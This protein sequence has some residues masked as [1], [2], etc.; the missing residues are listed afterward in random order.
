MKTTIIAIA[1][2]FVAALAPAFAQDGGGFAGPGP[3]VITVK[4]AKEMRDDSKVTL[5]GYI[6][7]HIGD[8]K[9]LFTDGTGSIRVEID[10][11]KWRGLTVGS[12]D[13]VEI[14][15]EVDKDWNSVEIEVDRISKA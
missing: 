13:L 10:R 3:G 9:Y 5:R 14:Q 2:V 8:D 12:K 11:D 7:Q 1:F 4:D 6:V 15:G